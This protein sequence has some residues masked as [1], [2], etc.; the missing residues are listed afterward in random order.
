MLTE[1]AQPIEPHGEV[2]KILAI[3]IRRLTNADAART[4]ENAHYLSNQGL[5]LVE[6][7]TLARLAI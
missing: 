2:V 5:R 7:S 6:V 3:T 1:D 4:S